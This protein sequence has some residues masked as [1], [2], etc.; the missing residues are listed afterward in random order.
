MKDLPAIGNIRIE[1]FDERPAA[2]VLHV[3]P[4]S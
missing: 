2:R 3:G 4:N 1:E